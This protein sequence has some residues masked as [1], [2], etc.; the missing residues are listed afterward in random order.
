[1]LSLKGRG[2]GGGGIW[3]LMGAVFVYMHHQRQVL[4][5]A[6]GDDLSQRVNWVSHRWGVIRDLKQLM[7]QLEKT[8]GSQVSWRKGNVLRDFLFST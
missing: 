7:D 3:N 8:R 1:M 6:F 2:R 5:K 4:K